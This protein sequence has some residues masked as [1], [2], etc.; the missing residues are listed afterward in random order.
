MTNRIAQIVAPAAFIG[1]TAGSMSLMAP[2]TPAVG[3]AR[4]GSVDMRMMIG[5]DPMCIAEI[6]GVPMSLC[7][8]PGTDPEEIAEVS[9]RLAARWAADLAAREQ[10]EGGASYQLGNRWVLSGSSAQGQPATLRWSVP[11]DGISVSDDL[12]GGAASPN[13]L[14]ATFTTKFGSVEAGKNL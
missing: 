9:Q 1:A 2:G 3:A 6:P 12:F 10:M 13:N 7:F 14:N 8:A 4:A 5:M 11:A